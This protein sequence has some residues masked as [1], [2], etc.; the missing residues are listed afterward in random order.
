MMQF[1]I[2]AERALKEKLGVHRAKIARNYGQHREMCCDRA[3]YNCRCVPLDPQREE[4][5][6]TRSGTIRNPDRI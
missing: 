2:R 4:P 1:T 6:T 5:R 3:E